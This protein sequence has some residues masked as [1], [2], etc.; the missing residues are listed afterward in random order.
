M[1]A[2]FF[3]DSRKIKGNDESYF[4]M[5]VGEQLRETVVPVDILEVFGLVLLLE[6]KNG[7]EIISVSALE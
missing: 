3:F 4:R 1:G 5:A 6:C 2:D 7:V